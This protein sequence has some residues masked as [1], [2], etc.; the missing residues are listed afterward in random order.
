MRRVHTFSLL[1]RR[2]GEGWTARCLDLGLAS[3]GATASDVMTDL[4]TSIGATLL[5]ERRRAQPHLT[6]PCEDLDDYAGLMERGR[7]MA[8]SE[9]ARRKRILA[10]PLAMTVHDEATPGAS[11]TY[12]APVAF[13]AVT[14]P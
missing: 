6:V 9:G 2:F 7:V 4:A 1:I 3:S 10:V 12:A 13:V 5:A 8:F 14:Q 11:Y